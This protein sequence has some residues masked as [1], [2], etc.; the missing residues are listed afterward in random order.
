[1]RKKK[2][3]VKLKKLELFFCFHSRKPFDKLTIQKRGF[4]FSA[5]EKPE[6]DMLRYD[7][8]YTCEKYPYLV[9]FVNREKGS[10]K[11][12]DA[13]WDSFWQTLVYIGKLKIINKLDWYTYNRNPIN[14]R[15]EKE[16]LYGNL[17]PYQEHHN[18]EKGYTQFE[19][20]HGDINTFDH[21]RVEDA[22]RKFKVT[23]TQKEGGEELR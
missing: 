5:L 20:K 8:C 7:N 22:L 21:E 16:S 6:P 18:I 4:K 14:Q 17:R 11:P 19:V 3:T 9:L 2:I 23:L 10:S 13:R 12:T 1:M 15:L